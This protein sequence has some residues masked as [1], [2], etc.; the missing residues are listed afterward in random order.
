MDEVDI[1][2]DN[3][4]KVGMIMQIH[5]QYIVRSGVIIQEMEQFINALV[6]DNQNKN[7]R[8]ENLT[9]EY[10]V[11]AEILRQHQMGQQ[12]IAEVMKRM[13]AG[14]N[15][16]QQQP[17]PHQGVAG[18]GPVVTEVD[19]NGGTDPNFPSAPSPQAGPPNDGGFGAPMNTFL[20]VPTSMELVTQF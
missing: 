4:Q 5:E 20:Q 12:V 19:D 9:T 16:G 14:N 6:Q 15:Q 7:V 3:F 8:I 18:T 1:H 11:H 2:R 13:M 10:Q 17:Q